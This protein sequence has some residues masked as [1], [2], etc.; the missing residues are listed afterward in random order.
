[1]KAFFRCLSPNRERQQFFANTCPKYPRLCIC[2]HFCHLEKLFSFRSTPPPAN[3][4]NK[5]GNVC[6]TQQR[7]VRVIIVAVEKQYILYMSAYLYIQISSTQIV[8]Y[9]TLI[10]ALFP[11][12]FSISRLVLQVSSCS[13]HQLPLNSKMIHSSDCAEYNT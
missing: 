4:F 6:I 13:L 7:R 12:W 11:F 9:I 5:T 8:S 1:M 2:I 3:E 10:K